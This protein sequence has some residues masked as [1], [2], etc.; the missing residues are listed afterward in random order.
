MGKIHEEAA[1]EV[2]SSIKRIPRIAEDVVD[3]LK[4]EETNDG[5]TRT[6][7]YWDPLGVCAS[8]LLGIFPWA[9]LRPL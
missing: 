6:I 2:E 4:S 3:A 5:V 1:N 7:S 9:C 8:I